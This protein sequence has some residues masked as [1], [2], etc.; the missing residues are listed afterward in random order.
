MMSFSKQV[1]LLMWKNLTQRRRQMKRNLM[2]I[3]WPSAIFIILALVRQRKPGTFPN[4][5]KPFYFVPRALPSAGMLPFLQS[6]FC[7]Y[8]VNMS[9]DQP[10]DISDYSNTIFS[11]L[12]ED[13]SPIVTNRT[14]MDNLKNLLATANNINKDVSYIMSIADQL[15]LNF[16][17]LIGSKNESREILVDSGLSLHAVESLLVSK[18]SISDAINFIGDNWN[19][20]SYNLT[21]IM[22]FNLVESLEFL[23]QEQDN[24]HVKLCNLHGLEKFIRFHITS[25]TTSIVS[26]LCS[27]KVYSSLIFIVIQ[28]REIIM[29]TLK[30]NPIIAEILIELEDASYYITTTTNEM[31][32]LQSLQKLLVNLNEM[33]Y[34]KD[35]SNSIDVSQLVC[36]TTK[37]NEVWKAT[38]NNKKHLIVPFS[39]YS[40]DDEF[41]LHSEDSQQTNNNPSEGGGSNKKCNSIHPTK[42]VDCGWGSISEMQCVKLACCYDNSINNAKYCF[43]PSYDKK[44][45]SSCCVRRRKLVE[46]ISMGSGYT[47]E[48]ANFITRLL[49][50]NVYYTPDNEKTREVIRRISNY[51]GSVSNGYEYFNSLRPLLRDLL[52]S[53]TIV[54]VDRLEKVNDLLQRIQNPLLLDILKR[55]FP[56]YHATFEESLP[57]AQH[58]IHVYRSY[59][60]SSNFGNTNY[61]KK[62]LN[63]TLIHTKEIEAALQCYNLSNFFIPIESEK[64]LVEYAISGKARSFLSSI[65][66]LNLND[67]TYW[68]STI[69]YKLRFNPD[70]TPSTSKIKAN[71]WRPGPG[72]M[73]K[74]SFFHYTYINFGF[75]FLQDLIERTLMGILTNRSI[76]EPGLY[77]QQFP[78]PCYLDDTFIAMLGNFMPLFMTLAWVYTIAM[79]VKSIVHEK[80][81]RLKEVMKVMGMD[82]SAHW[83]AWFLTS[84]FTILISI[85]ILVLLLHL[86]SI[87][88]Y[89][90]ATLVF[91]VLTIFGSASI[92]LA[93]LISVFFSNANVSAAC[94]GIIYFFTH[95]LYPVTIWF[96]EYMTTTHLAS[97]SLFSTTAFGLAFKYISRW[98]EQGIGAQWHNLFDNPMPGDKFS[99]GMA[100]IFMILDGFV[101]LLLAWYFENVLPGQFGIPKPW[102]FPFANICGIQSTV[103]PCS[104]RRGI[105]IAKAVDSQDSFHEEICPIHNISDTSEQD[106]TG[107]K[108]GVFIKNLVKVYERGKKR[109][110]DGLNIKMFEGQVTVLLGHNGA[111]KSTTMSILTGLFPPTSGTVLVND[112]DICLNIKEVRKSL[113]LCPQHDVLFDHLTVEEHM[114]FYGR[115][116]GLSDIILE[117]EIEKFLSDVG[118][119]KKRDELVRNLSGGMQRKLSVAMAFIANTKTVI[120]DEPTSGVDPESRRSIWDLILKS[121]QGR[122]ILLSTHYM[123]EADLLGDRICIM[124]NGKLQCSGSSLF[125]KRRFGKGFILTLS[126][127]DSSQA[128]MIDITRFI[129]TYIPTAEFHEDLNAEISFVLPSNSTSEFGKLFKA[130][131]RNMNQFGIKNYGISDTTLEEVFLKACNEDYIEYCKSAGNVSLTGSVQARRNSSSIN[132]CVIDKI[133]GSSYASKT[134]IA[135]D[136]NRRKEQNSFVLS[137]GISLYLAQFFGLIVK[138]FHH[139]RRSRKSYFSQI[140][141]PAVFVIMAMFVSYI[142]PPRT[143]EISLKLSTDMFHHKPNHIIL[144][145]SFTNRISQKLTEAYLKNSGSDQKL[146][147]HQKY[148][149]CQDKNI[150]LKHDNTTHH[151]QSIQEEPCSCATGKHDCPAMK[152]EPPKYQTKSGDVIIDLT[153]FNTTDYV[154]RTEDAYKLSRYGG[155]SFVSRTEANSLI[156]SPLYSQTGQKNYKV[157]YSLKGYHALPTFINLMNNAILQVNSDGDQDYKIIAYNHPMDFDTEQIEDIAWKNSI[158]DLFVAIFVITAMAFVPASFLVYLVQDKKSKS[159]HV[160][161]VSGLHPIVFW[162]GN[163]VWDLI[164]YMLPAICVMIIFLIFDQQAYVAP[165][166]VSCTFLLLLLY[167]WSMIPVMYPFSF[168]FDEPSTAYIIMIAVN[169]FVGIIGTLTTF[170]LEFFQDAGLEEINYYL[171][172]IFLIFPNYCLGRG[173]MD[174]AKNHFLS[175]IYYRFGTGEQGSDPLSW[176]LCG[177]N[178]SFMFLSGFVYMTFTL[179]CQYGVKVPQKKYRTQS[180]KTLSSDNDVLNEMN[181]INEEE[182]EGEKFILKTT[183]LTKIYQNRIRNR[184]TLAVDRLN[185]GVQHGECFGLLGVNGAG[186]TSTFKMLTGDS[187]IT[188]GDA[189]VNDLSIRKDK[190]LVHKYMGYCPQFDALDEL[191]TGRELLMYYSQIR[192]MQKQDGARKAEELSKSLGLTQYMDR[193]CGDYSGGNKRKLS[194]AISLLGSPSLVLMDEPTTGMD[195]GAR[196]FLWDVVIEQLRE[197]KSIVFTSHS[198]EECETLCTRIA[199]MVNGVLQC[200]G[201]PQHLRNK[202]GTGYTL[203]IR[204]SPSHKDTIPAL[205]LNCFKDAKLKDTHLYMFE[206][207]IKCTNILLSDIF[208]KLENL[209]KNKTIEDYSVTQTTLDQIFVDF[210]RLQ[211]EAVQIASTEI[212]GK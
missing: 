172:N 96:E 143:G 71:Y 76:S 17:D 182:K 1:A 123:D 199:I 22:G 54:L 188:S 43:C 145:S 131:E 117:Q 155:A 78:Y 20:A 100:I 72:P 80:E 30:K 87:F 162:M 32:T 200:L 21:K 193:I 8:R 77:I 115:L 189:L 101:Y 144:E 102:Y 176:Q 98:E 67:S 156:D 94:G 180:I 15:E 171:K 153:S 122:T 209:K 133:K 27:E 202:Y 210:A 130:L 9:M 104:T 166:N 128:D 207:Q 28:R 81:M 39:S 183:N 12:V 194:T 70:Y 191:L 109:A 26:E 73:G 19:E 59:A 56:Q 160:Q 178:I 95:L 137:T 69:E 58:Y 141:L 63:F 204:A 113:G 36:G 3:F 44:N 25:N 6:M 62:F 211:I 195:P 212:D 116:K 10:I 208:I 60:N 85:I 168:Y 33:I 118:L 2:E 90:D 146:T 124:S 65:V 105:K 16:T 89:S 154:L 24:I 164:N 97:V 50:G 140:L 206:F 198:M 147:C 66:F 83:T 125:L 174:L 186:K 5:K 157:W 114:N 177:Q 184:K 38:K 86:G 138:R 88:T 126:R 132:N 129:T 151:F 170:I 45:G 150:S 163:Y 93:F 14:K 167:G 196:R 49:E 13:A 135:K 108:V 7:N 4:N 68:P 40:L 75:V 175:E 119:S 203:L 107:L 159:K 92:A 99:L 91:L 169:L 41:D 152:N 205:I 31:S 74:N 42:R 52:D 161:L 46:I 47:A 190:N 103:S 201:S 120:L 55:Q 23:V 181:R 121:K 142:R 134:S 148:S 158:T 34:M 187:D 111:G 106:P 57:Q 136:V 139:A 173:L 53:P 185:I 84:L 165:Q 37:S 82:T 64:E 197:G 48:I 18:I 35:E 149:Y 127:G 11:K 29:D 51:L 112:N 79:V 179:V 110:V 192:G 61:L